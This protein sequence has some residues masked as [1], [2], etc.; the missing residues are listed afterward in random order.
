MK[1]H[2]KPLAFFAIAL[3]ILP[4]LHRLNAQQTPPDVFEG[5]ELVRPE[6]DHTR[7]T[8]VR[9]FFNADSMTIV[10]KSGGPALKQ[11]KYSEIRSAEYSYSKNPRWKTGLGLGAASVLFPPLILVAIPIGFT[12]HRRHW[13]TL[14]TADDFAVLKVSKKVRKLFMPAFETRTGV[15]IKALGDDK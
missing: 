15:T 5:L 12:K 8:D 13:V 2:I 14:R 6:G 1:L 9:L 4:P 10:S 3:I 11:W 7:E